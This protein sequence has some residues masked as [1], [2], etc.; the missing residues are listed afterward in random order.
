[1]KTEIGLLLRRW[2]ALSGG[3]AA[4]AG[5]VAV[6]QIVSPELPGPVGVVFEQNLSRNVDASALFYS[7]VTE[8]R[9]FLDEDGRYGGLLYPPTEIGGGLQVVRPI[10]RI[11][12]GS[13]P[14]ISRQRR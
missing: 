2:L 11:Q 3:L 1:M 12:S 4:I 6:A 9:E 14:A 8:I 13:E 7:E 10:L 5:F